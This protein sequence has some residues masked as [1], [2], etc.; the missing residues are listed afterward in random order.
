MPPK[1]RFIS[2]IGRHELLT[3]PLRLLPDF[4][5]IGGRCCGT[6]SLYAYLTAHPHVVAAAT[7]E[8]HFFDDH[9]ADGPGWYRAHFPLRWER[10]LATLVRREPYVTGEA[11]PFYLYHPE[12]PARLRS[13][14][15]A[16]RLL[17]LLRNPVDRAFSH[18]QQSRRAGVE[19]LSFEEALEAEPARLRE[20]AFDGAGS[21]AMKDY[22]YAARGQYAEQLAR[23]LPRFPREQLLVTQSEALFAAPEG[24]MRRVFEFLG[25]PHAAAGRYRRHHAGRY[26]ERM[27]PSTRE[28]LERQFAPHN[29]RLFELLG[30]R[31]DWDAEGE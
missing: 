12:V 10:L 11:S 21:G 20:A 6:T 27:Q 3:A 23:W 31:Y 7:K 17:V 18:Y 16:A 15:P 4:I 19:P 9:W 13:L 26:E 5:I 8:V 1:R 2:R 28:R 14:C 25:L 29:E 24:Q 30:E 22:S